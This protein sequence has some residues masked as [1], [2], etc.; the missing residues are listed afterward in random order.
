MKVDYNFIFI[1][2]QVT[3]W[4]EGH[5]SIYISGA[6]R[7]NSTWQ[8]YVIYP[9]IMKIGLFSLLLFHWQL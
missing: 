4:I 9:Y 6:I 8:K 3:T 7:D 5:K 2:L 1:L